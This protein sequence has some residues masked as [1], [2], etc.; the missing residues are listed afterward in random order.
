[1]KAL[2][3]TFTLKFRILGASFT[4]SMA[5]L[6]ACEKSPAPV[7]ENS[8]IVVC[9]N[10]PG[11]HVKAASD[12]VEGEFQRLIA[13]HGDQV[14]NVNYHK[15]DPNRPD[16]QKGRGPLCMRSAVRSEAAASPAPA[17]PMNLVQRVAFADLDEAQQTL[18]TIN[19]TAMPT[20]TPT[21][22]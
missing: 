12:V 10:P 5:L 8:P 16:W 4:A 11:V 7:T 18:S 21:S 2:S 9:M 22:P 17:D 19:S 14:C 20:P 1:M 15:N 13:K 6:S 3:G